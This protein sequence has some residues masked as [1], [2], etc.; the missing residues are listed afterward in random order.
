MTLTTIAI[1]MQSVIKNSENAIIKNCKCGLFS[2]AFVIK[3]EEGM[4][5]VFPV[6]LQKTDK[7]MKT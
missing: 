3:L 4:A 6:G 5:E 7:C 1:K 2:I